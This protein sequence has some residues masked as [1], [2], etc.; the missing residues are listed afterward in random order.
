MKLDMPLL[1]PGD[2]AVLSGAVRNLER[3]LAVE[4]A[5][6]PAKRGRSIHLL[7]QQINACRYIASQMDKTPALW[8]DH[9]HETLAKTK[10]AK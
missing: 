7:C 3:L 8:I 4:I 5:R 9:A 1:H 10:G 2:A 6:R